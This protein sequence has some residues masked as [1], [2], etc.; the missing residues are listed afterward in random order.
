MA[1]P[2]PECMPC[3]GTGQVVS[4]LGGES[5]QVKCPWCAGTGVRTAG[6]DAQ[7]AWRDQP[8][9]GGDGAEQS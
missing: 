8:A 6:V 2:A 5:R 1:T 3:H 4:N 9:V 7:A